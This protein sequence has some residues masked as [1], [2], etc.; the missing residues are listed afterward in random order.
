MP[1][2][3]YMGKFEMVRSFVGYENNLQMWGQ[4]WLN[5]TANTIGG[6]LL[7]SWSQLG[8]PY[9]TPKMHFLD[10]S[11]GKLYHVILQ[12]GHSMDLHGEDTNIEPERAKF[13]R[14]MVEKWELEWL[15]DE[16]KKTLSK[17]S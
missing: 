5:R 3:E 6:W 4:L 12:I 17:N 2:P 11:D 8:A 13:I 10:K 9:W 14:K 16:A 1:T 7:N 15:K